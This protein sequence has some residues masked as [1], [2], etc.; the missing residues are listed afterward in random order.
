MRRLISLFAALALLVALAPGALATS[1]AIGVSGIIAGGQIVTLTPLGLP[2]GAH[3]DWFLGWNAVTTDRDSLYRTNMSEVE[4]LSPCQVWKLR[5]P[6]SSTNSWSIELWSDAIDLHKTISGSAGAAG[7]PYS[8]LPMV[9][10]RTIKRA[11]VGETVKGT[12]TAALNI[13]PCALDWSVFPFNGDDGHGATRSADCLSATWK[14]SAAGWYD[15]EATGFQAPAIDAWGMAD[16]LVSP[17]TLTTSIPTS[18]QAGVAFGVLASLPP[19]SST[20][21]Y[22]WY[23][24]STLIFSG[25]NNGTGT[26]ILSAGTKTITVKVTS[27]AGLSL[28]RSQTIVVK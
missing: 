13:A 12:L 26:M 25:T 10:V 9:T 14:A 17:A 2:S 20:L 1:P 3:C 24:G 22:R 7:T 19:T 15:I 11:L 4:N 16:F 23:I 21:T 18:A 27:S 6:V 28:S 5:L 8:S